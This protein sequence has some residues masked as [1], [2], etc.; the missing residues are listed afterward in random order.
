[1]EVKDVNFK[2][3]IADEGMAL[4]WI[5]TEWDYIHQKRYNRTHMSPYDAVIDINNLVGD[6]EEIPMKEFLDEHEYLYVG[7]LGRNIDNK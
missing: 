4:K 6:V 1:M 2:R 5:N 7:V 3:F